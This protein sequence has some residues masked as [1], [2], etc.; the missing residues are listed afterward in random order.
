MKDKIKGLIIGILISAMLFSTGV[1]A[2]VGS[3]QKDL[4]Y[5]NIK[6]TLDNQEITPT[7]ANGSYVEP[8]IIDG[9]T[10]L[11]V[12]AVSNALG[13]SVDWDANTNT[14]KLLSQG[15]FDAENNSN[16]RVIKFS[17]KPGHYEIKD[18]AT[19]NIYEVTQSGDVYFEIWWYG[20]TAFGGVAKSISE[21]TASFEFVLYDEV[22]KG[23]LRT[24]NNSIDIE[25]FSAFLYSDPG[26]YSFDY[27]G[28]VTANRTEVGDQFSSEKLI[29]THD[30]FEQFI[31]GYG[32]DT[33]DWTYLG[34]PIYFECGIENGFDLYKI[35]TQHDEIQYYALTTAS[36]NSGT[37][38]AYEFLPGGEIK[39]IWEELSFTEVEAKNFLSEIQGY[40]ACKIDSYCTFMQFEDDLW[41]SG[42]YQSE[43]VPDEYITQVRKIGNNQFEVLTH[44]PATYAF[45]QFIREEYNTYIL[46]S[47]D[48]FKNTLTVTNEN[49]YSTL[50]IFA[51]KSYESLANLCDS[52]LGY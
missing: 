19:L 29:Y 14:V 7:D 20:G 13:L 41:K 22:I 31:N 8:F 51:G 25:L 11:P 18:E 45:E 33:K 38:E 6:I 49:G 47:T 21:Q 10:Y 35:V 52:L 44:Q 42:F 3:V 36:N 16:N 32:I 28:N 46:S 34:S 40:W 48:D 2:T 30:F 4:W 15:E 12:R 27:A 9:T 17:G 43:G 1:L 26:T 39:K 24:N 37:L 5:N 50:F 23:E